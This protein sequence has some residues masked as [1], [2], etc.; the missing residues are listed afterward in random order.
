[1]FLLR[2]K[3]LAIILIILLGFI[4]PLI[5]FIN[6]I[7]YP[8]FFTI[9][10]AEARQII[11]EIINQ[12]VE[13]EIASIEYE[14][15]IKYECD[16][17]GNIILLQQNTNQINHLSSQIALNIQK[18]FKKI[19]AI[20]IEVPMGRFIG[21][22][23]LSGMGPVFDVK[24]IPGGFVSTPEIIDEFQSAGINQTRHKLY[25]KLK[26]DSFLAAPF[27]QEKFIITTEIPVIEV[28]ILGRVPQIY[29]GRY[30]E[31][32]PVSPQNR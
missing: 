28:T 7:I 18:N 1:M 5:I 21:L 15:L 8:V 13:E 11:H 31:N 12:S 27:S 30:Q 19:K 9:A 17:Q 4:I 2:R 6:K 32:F 22:E 29:L 24:V 23:I 25:L 10:E 3:I 14:D 16:E 20:K 26:L